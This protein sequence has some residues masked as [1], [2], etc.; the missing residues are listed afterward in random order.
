M[1]KILTALSVAAISVT[2]LQAQSYKT[3]A[4]L[5]I[6]FGNGSTWAGPAIKHFFDNR[7]AINAEL[8]FGGNTT[9]L[10]AF[11]QFHG[12]IKNAG[13]LKYYLGIGPSLHFPK[14][15]DTYFGIRPMAGLDYKI[16]STPLA[17][18]FDWRPGVF[19]H[20]NNSDFE[21]GRFAFGLKFAFN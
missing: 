6:E 12:P 7:N 4:G 11:Y 14:R 1:K 8:L 3:A 10:Q 17:L 2:G 19:I 16:G 13:G 20:D 21:A 18:S 9:T 5:T 15:G